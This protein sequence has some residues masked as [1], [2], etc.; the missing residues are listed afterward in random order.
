MQTNP[1][2]AT[3]ALL[4]RA[5]PDA[6]SKAHMQARSCQPTPPG[7]APN[8]FRSAAFEAPPPSHRRAPEESPLDAEYK[9]AEK[10]NETTSVP[11]RLR[12]EEAKTNTPSAT[13]ETG[14]YYHAA[15]HSVHAET[16]LPHSSPAAQ[17]HR[18]RLQAL[19]ADGTPPRPA[20]EKSVH[21]RVHSACKCIPKKCHYKIYLLQV[22]A[23]KCHT[24]CHRPAQ[25]NT[26]LPPPTMQREVRPGPVY[27]QS[28]PP[29]LQP[30]NTIGDKVSHPAADGAPNPIRKYCRYRN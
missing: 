2:P 11:L 4:R 22:S 19:C 26:A 24:S 23:C 6:E 27:A 29:T 17:A 15:A 3:H 9:S 21:K 16:A 10:M 20:A 28:I 13:E 7:N 12:P 5:A 30:G 8:C 1:V 18:L 14:T 25:S